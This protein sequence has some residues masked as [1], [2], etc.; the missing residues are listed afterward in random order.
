M[1]KYK[2]AEAIDIPRIIELLIDDNLGKTREDPSNMEPYLKAF[3]DI[4]KDPNQHLMVM[5]LDEKIIGTFHLTIIPSLGRAGSKRA[6]IESV[7]IDKNFRGQ[8]LGEQMIAEAI[9]IA[10]EN[11]AVLVQLTTDKSR[12][13]AK[14]FYERLGFVASHEGMKIKIG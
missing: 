3:A 6:N 14:R 9:R 5:L 12:I 11:S 1:I 13:D 7:R 2:L 8:K 10:K 4:Q